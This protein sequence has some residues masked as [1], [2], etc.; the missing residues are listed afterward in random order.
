MTT[1]LKMVLSE[2]YSNQ[3]QEFGSYNNYRRFLIHGSKLRANA[4]KLDLFRFE[5]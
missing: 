2:L 4:A 3:G 5:G 1:I